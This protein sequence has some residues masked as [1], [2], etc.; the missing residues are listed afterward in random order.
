MGDWRTTGDCWLTVALCLGCLAAQ[1]ISSSGSCRTFGV[2]GIILDALP[3]CL[4][5]II[6]SFVFRRAFCKACP[7]KDWL[8]SWF[9]CCSGTSKT[10]CK[11]CL[12]CLDACL[13]FLGI[14][15]LLRLELRFECDC[16]G[17]ARLKTDSCVCWSSCSESSL[18]AWSWLASFKAVFCAWASGIERFWPWARLEAVPAWSLHYVTCSNFV[19]CQQLERDTW[20]ISS[21]IHQLFLRH[22]VSASRPNTARSHY[23]FCPHKV[24]YILTEL[25]IKRFDFLK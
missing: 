2:R 20:R 13:S 6:F 16:V 17:A 24:T 14:S 18:F 5:L 25:A 1:A 12:V 10:A 8:T 22:R 15:L 9:C 19:S 3:C 23:H 11:L 4:L 21:A 7:G